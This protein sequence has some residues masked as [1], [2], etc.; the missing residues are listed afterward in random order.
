[1]PYEVVNKFEDKED[2][3]TK[4]IVGDEYPKG[5]YKPTKKRIEELSTI[6]PEK[7]RVFIKEIQEEKTSEPSPKK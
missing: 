3:G 4:Y 2:K 6:H 1:M 5:N 7:K